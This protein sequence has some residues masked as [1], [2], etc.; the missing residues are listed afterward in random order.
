[1]FEFLSFVSYNIKL[2]EL[3]MSFEPC[4]DIRLKGYY[5]SRKNE[6]SQ[7]GNLKKDDTKENSP[8]RI[9]SGRG[10]GRILRGRGYGFIGV[11]PKDQRPG[12]II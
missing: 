1:M 2:L 4:A 5:K 6:P 9:Y 8:P 7:T 3:K 10:R 12:K 11:R